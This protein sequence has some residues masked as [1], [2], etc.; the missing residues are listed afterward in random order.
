MDFKSELLKVLKILSPM[1]NDVAYDIIS[2][3]LIC[4]REHKRLYCAF[5]YLAEFIAK[6]KKL[7]S[8]NNDPVTQ[9]QITKCLDEITNLKEYVVNCKNLGF[10][11]RYND[12]IPNQNDVEDAA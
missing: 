7:T 6:G 3:M 10:D 11:Q 1:K 8:A 5:N 2:Y 12:S 4:L 9:N